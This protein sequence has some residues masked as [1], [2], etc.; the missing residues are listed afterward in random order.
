[1]K[2][3]LLTN[4]EVLRNKHLLFSL[5]L[6][7]KKQYGYE[8]SFEESDKYSA[9]ILIIHSEIKYN[10]LIKKL[11]AHYVANGKKV[12]L[13]AVGKQQVQLP[14]Y[15]KPKRFIEPDRLLDNVSECLENSKSIGTPVLELEM[16]SFIEACDNLAVLDRVDARL[17]RKI[18][19]TRI[20]QL[21]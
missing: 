14:V 16:F 11:Q 12:N 19:D 9:D 3:Y 7:I 20:N 5:V 8:V 18:L 13:L 17:K 6:N 4:K 1:M 15:G 21:N 10:K 2:A